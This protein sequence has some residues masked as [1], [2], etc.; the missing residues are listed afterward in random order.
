MDRKAR[1]SERPRA[2]TI[3]CQT[4]RPVRSDVPR[5][6]CNTPPSQRAYCTMMGA[7]SPRRWRTAASWTSVAFSPNN[8]TAASP[9]STWVMPKTM[10]DTT[11]RVKR[12]VAILFR[13]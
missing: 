8:I 10:S 3:I 4:G 1:R 9:G 13:R 11:K 6:P 5:S 7:S 2:G 12:I